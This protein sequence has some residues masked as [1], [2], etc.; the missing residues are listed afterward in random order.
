M[1]HMSCSHVVQVSLVVGGVSCACENEF[2]SQ[3]D[4]AHFARVTEARTAAQSH[5]P[6]VLR[7][8][9]LL[10]ESQA[11]LQLADKL[12][13]RAKEKLHAKGQTLA[14]AREQSH[15][16]FPAGKASVFIVT[17]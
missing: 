4:V 16:L 13:E 7:D 3:R 1:G 9:A 6:V 8:P 2:N 17:T 12:S 14:N 11:I 15:L 10:E 5:P